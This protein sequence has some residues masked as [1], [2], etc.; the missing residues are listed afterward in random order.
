[1]HPVQ[2]F[3][4]KVFSMN[5]FLPAFSTFSTSLLRAS[6]TLLAGLT[7]FLQGC[8]VPVDPVPAPNASDQGGQSKDASLFGGSVPQAWFVL[9]LRLIK[10]SAGFTP[11]VASRAL[12][13][14]SV[15][16][17]ES[18]VQGADGYESLAGQ[19]NGFST[20]PALRVPNAEYQWEASAN[21][22]CAAVMRGLFPSTARAS[23][24]SLEMLIT[25][26][27][28]S[29][30]TQSTSLE[31]TLE[32]TLERS[33]QFGRA[34]AASVLAWAA[35][36]GAGVSGAAPYLSNFP[37]WYTPVAGAGAWVP[38]STGERALQPRWGETRTF[39]APN[40]NPSILAP[41]P[42]AYSTDPS[43][44][45]YRQGR[46]TYDISKTLTAEQ[47][48]IA[49]FWAD[50]PARTFTP[51]GHSANIALQVLRRQ[52]NGTGAS[53]IASAETLAKTGIAVADAFIC[54]WRTKYTHNILRP[55]TY[56]QRVIE[57]AWTPLLNTPPFP[58]YTSGHACQSAAAAQVLAVLYGST[59]AFV[60]SSH[61][62]R[63]FAPRSFASFAASAE[64]AGTSRIYGGI[65]Y[66][67]ANTQGIAEGRRV[68]ANVA[69]LRTKRDRVP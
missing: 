52:N 5:R 63:G 13:Y 29:A 31:R 3:L 17:Y 38:T 30:N 1:V 62:D 66:P 10:E 46:A 39:V 44:E 34:V 7:F 55:I 35:G 69:Q 11:P 2:K 61:A 12:G 9:E 20:L 15:A 8:R 24:D 50:D 53:L 54:C 19:L 68:G 28:Q 21:A 47:R 26:R 48:V 67:M 42:P 33:Q 60:D 59:T 22:A 18:V 51:P 45:F 27:L 65:H 57:P 16:L 41:P 4:T 23:I 64:E 40:A 25:T 32:R 36:D 56:I 14:T 43:S 37:T 49:Q 6:L 58:E